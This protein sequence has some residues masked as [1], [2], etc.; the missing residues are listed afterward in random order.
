[1]NYQFMQIPQEYSISEVQIHLN[2][3]QIRQTGK[4]KEEITILCHQAKTREALVRVVD[5]KLLIDDFNFEEVCQLDIQ[6]CSIKF[7][8][9]AREALKN[10]INEGRVPMIEFD[11]RTY[12][13]ESNGKSI[14]SLRVGSRGL[15]NI[16]QD[17]R[18][19]LVQ[20]FE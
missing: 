17:Q 8:H 16:I 4:F 3:L 14:Q 11:E 6:T 2:S 18:E 13:F 5:L 10:A 20:E 19:I 15:L 9:F 7:G 1:M 12:N